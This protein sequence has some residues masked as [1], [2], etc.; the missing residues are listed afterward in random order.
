ME[1]LLEPDR[2]PDD[3]ARSDARILSVVR[4]TLSFFFADDDRLTRLWYV[5]QLQNRPPDN[6]A[7]R[8]KRAFRPV[9]TETPM[10]IEFG[11]AIFDF[12]RAIFEFGRV[13]LALW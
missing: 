7:L 5:P 9:N 3:R 2:P 13:V 10:S 8:A 11:R 4:T 6:R 1:L 12:G